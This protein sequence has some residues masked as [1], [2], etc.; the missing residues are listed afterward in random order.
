MV[1]L[2]TP[3]ISLHPEDCACT[4]WLTMTSLDFLSE[5]PMEK[6]DA[7][8][9]EEVLQGLQFMPRW[10]PFIAFYLVCNTM[11]GP[12]VIEATLAYRLWED[13]SEALKPMLEHAIEIKSFAKIRRLRELFFFHEIACRPD[14]L[15]RHITPFKGR[16][17]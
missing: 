2:L 1:D 9:D 12:S 15:A 7:R 13:H 3:F 17:S 8:M 6:D 10:D 14:L 11:K 5:D 4:I 16:R